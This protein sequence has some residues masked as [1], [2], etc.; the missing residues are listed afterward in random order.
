MTKTVELKSSQTAR[1]IDMG[2]AG[3]RVYEAGTHTVGDR[4]ARI[5]VEDLGVASYADNAVAEVKKVAGPKARTR[6]KVTK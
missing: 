6:R 1:D 4:L 3:A 2:A 5:W